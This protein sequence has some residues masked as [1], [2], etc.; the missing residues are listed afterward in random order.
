MAARLR[1]H[2]LIERPE[3]PNM[4]ATHWQ[5]V[6]KLFHS[7]LAMSGTA[8]VTFLEQE[9][10]GDEAVRAEVESLLAIAEGVGDFLEPHPSPT[11]PEEAP[12]PTG[13]RVGGYAVRRILGVGGMGVVYEAEQ[14]KLHRKV[15]L[16]LIRP[17][18]ATKSMIARFEYEAQLVGRLQHPGIAQVFEAGLHRPKAGAHPLQTGSFDEEQP[19]FAMELIRGVPITEFAQEHDIDQTARLRLL[20]KVCDAVEHAHQRGVIHRDL[21]PANILVVVDN[22]KGEDGTCEESDHQTEDDAKR[23][24]FDS[25]QPKILDFGIARAIDA[26]FR[27]TVLRTDAGQLIGTLPYMSPEQV[28]GDPGAVDTRSD[29]Y[30][31]GVLGYELLTDRLPYELSG[32]TIPEAVQIIGHEEP[33]TLSSIDP[34]LGGDLQVIIGKALEKNKE[35]RYGSSSHFAADIR[36]F[37][38]QEPILARPP[39]TRY[40][41]KKLITRH[42][43]PF[44]FAMSLLLVIFIGATGAVWQAFR[45]ARQRDLAQAAEQQEKEARAAA[46]H[47]ASFL[48]TL[49]EEANPEFGLE[50]ELSVRDLL[51]SGVEKLDTEL[52]DQPL[53]R[54]RLMTVVGRVCFKLRDFEAAQRLLESGLEIRTKELG[55]DHPALVENLSWLGT[56]H[57]ERGAPREAENLFRRALELRTGHYGSAHELVAESWSDLGA[58]YYYAGDF[59]A[60]AHSERQ[61]LEIYAN[62]EGTE[63]LNGAKTQVAL[64]AS[65]KGLG[66]HQESLAMLRSALATQRALLG[67]HHETERTLNHLGH[68]LHAMGDREQSEQVLAKQV[69]MA[70]RIFGNNHPR[71]AAALHD[72]AFQVR[73]RSFD[74][75]EPLYRKELAIACAALGER[76]PYRGVGDERL[77]NTAT[78]TVQ[79]RRSDHALAQGCR[80]QS[81]ALRRLRRPNPEHHEQSGAGLPAGRTPQRGRVP[82]EGDSSRSTETPRN[83]R[84]ADSG[85]PL[86][87]RCCSRRGG[88][89]GGRGGAVPHGCRYLP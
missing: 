31:L 47:V 40:Q 14:E 84:A 12:E 82:P 67:D 51:R 65:L 2:A 7:A 58:F 11:D 38:N 10:G 44:L 13:T 4:D 69:A 77:G 29:V 57:S 80:D 73:R 78:Q 45:F 64:A 24:S 79:D 71:I 23:V 48:E 18:M 60:A 54:A 88:R 46:E 19:F 87:S 36:R 5:K 41:L 39:S 76:P 8:R 49:F 62:I 85:R 3:R 30:A 50:T 20:A 37:L 43:V 42:R 9:S 63:S 75:A 86:Q 28:T 35:R 21:K 89:R 16:K 15:A 59:D 61:A 55:A 53:V 1:R 72:Y 56:L 22:A 32:K 81:L 17:G 70:E 26:D 66:K 25:I 34:R 27:S 74:E 83:I 68:T 6:R 33:T 52:V